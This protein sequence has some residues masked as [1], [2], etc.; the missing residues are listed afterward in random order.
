MCNGAWHLQ[1][2]FCCT[3]VEVRLWHYPDR[4]EEPPLRPL[5][6]SVSG[7]PKTPRTHP[8]LPRRTCGQ[9]AD[10]VIFSG[11]WGRVAYSETHEAASRRPRA[12]EA[13]LPGGT[14]EISAVLEGKRTCGGQG[15]LKLCL[16]LKVKLEV[17]DCG[18]PSVPILHHSLGTKS[19][20]PPVR[21]R[22]LASGWFK[23][24]CKDWPTASR[25][26]RNAVPSTGLAYG[27]NGDLASR[28][29]ACLSR[30][31]DCLMVSLVRLTCSS[32]SARVRR[33]AAITS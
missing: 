24:F 11:K 17:A 31:L 10:L 19:G 15:A 12:R 20:M 14:R 4:T 33:A 2:P 16:G 9:T 26:Q 7:L 27:F 23:H 18:A 1:A 28:S 25:S 13:E 32:R 22:W 3:A 29:S 21:V 8:T 6:G 30:S 5:S